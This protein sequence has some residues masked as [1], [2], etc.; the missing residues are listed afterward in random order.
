MLSGFAEN[1]FKY[2]DATHEYEEIV[3]PRHVLNAKGIDFFNKLLLQRRVGMF[4]GI[5]FASKATKGRALHDSVTNGTKNYDNY[6][7]V[8]RK[9]CIF[10]ARKFMFPG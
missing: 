6:F 9:E 10:A 4:S 7:V 8:S 5:F 2:P 3:N 1:D